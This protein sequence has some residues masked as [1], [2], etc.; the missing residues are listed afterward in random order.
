MDI[1]MRGIRSSR[2]C[3]KAGVKTEMSEATAADLAAGQHIQVW[4]I[5]SGS[6]LKATQICIVKVA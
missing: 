3:T 2:H 5:S 1:R 4:G 6:S